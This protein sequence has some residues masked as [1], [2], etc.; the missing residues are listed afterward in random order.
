[1]AITNKNTRLLHRK[2]WQM[3]TS[4]PISSAN[5]ITAIASEDGNFDYTLYLTSTTGAW[6]YSHDED[7]W[8][9]APSPGLSGTFGSGNAGCFSRW[10]ST[11][12]TT[13]TGTATTAVITSST[14]NI[15]Q[16]AVGQ[17][18]EFLSG[19][20]VIGNRG[21]VTSVVN[22]PAG[23]V[24]ITFSLIGSINGG[25][26]ATVPSGATFRLSTG[27]FFVL[28]AGTVASGSFKF[29][30]V[31]TNSWNASAISI[32]NLPSTWGT[33]GRMTSTFNYGE[34]YGTGTAT[35][36]TATTLVN[37]SKSWTTNQWSNY[38]VRITGGTGLGQI[39]SIAS[40]TATTL[41][42]STW[43]TTPD[44]TSTYVIEGN[45]DY[46]YLIGNG[47]VTLYRYSISANTWSVP[48][49]TAARAVAPGAGESLNYIG[50]SNSSA[51]ADETNIKDGRYLYSFRGGATAGLDR[52]DI[53]LNTWAAITYAPANEG[54]STGSGNACSHNL[55]YL[56][57]SSNNRYFKYDVVTNT[58]LPFSTNLYSDGTAATGNRLW[59]RNYQSS[60]SDGS[61]TIKWLYSIQNGGASMHRIM[62]Y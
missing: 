25:T 58:L 28:C 57:S 55:I 26:G 46:L 1:M 33:E 52:Y 42:V 51:W 31:A 47:A 43:T 18:I 30:D 36:A 27:R 50:K 10:S 37:T 61:E 41:T 11:F 16:P 35:S 21:T 54:F 24:V 34:T 38:Q 15:G 40:N 39:R 3:M 7:S 8:V 56:R 49:P 62:I 32:T 14:A 22:D 19:T 48:S 5:G 6:L 29:Y 12:T 13:S 53:A 44:A 59:I 23:N 45:E 20:G 2:E 4:A 9:Q 17:I 60:V